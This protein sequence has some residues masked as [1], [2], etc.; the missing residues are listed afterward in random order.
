MEN[1]ER[2]ADTVRSRVRRPWTRP[3]LGS[4]AC[5]TMIAAIAMAAP[6]IAHAKVHAVDAARGGGAGFTRQ[7]RVSAAPSG[8]NAPDPFLVAVQR[9]QDRE[10]SGADPSSAPG[11]LHGYTRMNSA[12]GTVVYTNRPDDEARRER[13]MQRAFQPSLPTPD[14]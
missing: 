11:N 13:F 2:S 7:D 10:E 6:A 1:I 3:S 12:D 4:L 8:S 9:F 14:R 5:G